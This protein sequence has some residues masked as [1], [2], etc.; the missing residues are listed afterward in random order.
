MIGNLNWIQ[1]A[2]FSDLCLLHLIDVFACTSSASFQVS[3]KLAS[4]QRGTLV[5]PYIVSH[6][7]AGQPRLIHIVERSQSSKPQYADTFE[8]FS[9]VPVAIVPLT[10]SSHM[11][12]QVPATLQEHEHREWKNLLPFLQL[13]TAQDIKF[14]SLTSPQFLTENSHSERRTMLGTLYTSP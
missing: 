7:P 9:Y 2:H 13:I 11:T 12:R 5:L 8:V 3:W 6:P 1:W 14:Y 10:Q 4:S